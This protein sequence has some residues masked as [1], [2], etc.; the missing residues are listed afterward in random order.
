[1]RSLRVYDWYRVYDVPRR[2]FMVRGLEGCGLPEVRV[3]EVVAVV[4][5]DVGSIV[6]YVEIVEVWVYYA[7]RWGE[8]ILILIL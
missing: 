5:A 7:C 6:A 2:L 1:M 8:I 4:W 3:D